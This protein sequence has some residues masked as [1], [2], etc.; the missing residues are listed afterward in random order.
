M[1]NECLKLI[2]N[3]SISS[4]LIEF[5]SEFTKI[6]KLEVLSFKGTSG[7]SKEDFNKDMNNIYKAIHE[8]DLKNVF[9]KLKELKTKNFIEFTYRFFTKD[10]KIIV[11][12]SSLNVIERNKEKIV[13]IG[14]NKDISEEQTY[15]SIFEKL[16]NS[17]S[18]GVLLYRDE[19]IYANDFMKKIFNI[20]DMTK[21]YKLL[22][23]IKNDHQEIQNYIDK[24]KAGED[25]FFYKER[26]EFISTDNKRYYLNSY[27]NTILYNGIYVGFALLTDETKEVKKEMFLKIINE[28]SEKI[29]NISS[30]KEFLNE[31]KKS[32]SK[33]YICEIIDE[34]LDGIFISK[35]GKILKIG[36]KNLTLKMESEYIDEFN[37]EYNEIY[38]ELRKTL[39]FGF[40]NIENI[41]LLKILKEAIEKSYQWVMIIDEKG[42]ILYVNDIVTKLSGYKKEELI[43]NRITIFKSPKYDE[44]FYKEMLSVI[45]KNQLFEDIFIQTNK[46]DEEIYLKM[47]IVPIEVEDN[48]FFV[49]LG[50]DLTN[51]KK[52]QQSLL[53]D[54]L[55]AL[56]NRKGLI[57]KSN[58]KDET[59]AL[60]LIDI[61]EFKIY[62]QLY[63]TNYGD[64][65]LKEF[66]I[67]LKTFF[68]EDDIIARLSADKFAVLIKYTSEP[69][70]KKI[71]SRLIKKLESFDIKDLNINIGVALYPQDAKNLYELIEK[72]SIALSYAKKA[73]KNEYFFY[74][75]NIKEKL[76]QIEY[77]K[78][79]INKALEEDKFIYYFQPYLSLDSNRI[80]GA[81]ALLRIEDNGE[82]ISPGVFI[83]YAEQKGL[84]KDIEKKMYKKLIEVYLPKINIPISFNVSAISFKDEEHI[85]MLKEGKNLTIELTEREIAKNKAKVNQIFNKL[86][87]SGFK[88]AVDDFG[89]GYASFAYIKWLNFD[90]LKI[91]MEYIKNITS[92]KDFAIVKT[93]I[94]LAKQLNI[95]TIAEGVENEKQIKILKNLGCDAIQGFYFAKPMPFE[96]FI[97]FLKGR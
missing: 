93:I 5:N 88:I 45:N 62:N 30:K 6:L 16:K 43:G 44:N 94:T 91:D 36:F 81:E 97:E 46:Y 7:W 9:A 31:I 52:L 69:Q 39:E 65:I 37:K 53:S 78:D 90:V 75:E 96:E 84:I 4:Y 12:K 49:A 57:L 20:N 55:T 86:R 28:I 40:Y 24:R 21:T 77:I 54:D 17:P 41:G 10:E 95:K 68:Y 64:Y 82:I 48:K 79:L 66:A 63:G 29:L 2:E 70:L 32:I 34:Y 92:P 33:Y 89:S 14:I 72:A 83:N 1:N 22:S 23:F 35:N 73:G 47:K 67:F 11:V 59:Y 19:I 80:V 58:L 87:K 60:L 76:K 8:D 51:E 15:K 61:C 42:K 13:C 85:N 71:I 18:I 26:I 56:L 50:I 25:V 27:A 74:D 3:I 38:N